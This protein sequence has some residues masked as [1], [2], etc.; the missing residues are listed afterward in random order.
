MARSTTKP[1]TKRQQ[2]EML[3]MRIKEWEKG[4]QAGKDMERKI[5]EAKYAKA[6]RR[7]EELKEIRLLYSMAGQTLEP[8]ARVLAMYLD[9]SDV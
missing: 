7:M 1:L 4:F 9:R 3:Q 2:L 8:L 6:A 5:A